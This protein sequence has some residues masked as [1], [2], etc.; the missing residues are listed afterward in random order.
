MN[1]KEAR[2]LARVNHIIMLKN[3]CSSL[4]DIFYSK[5]NEAVAY[6]KTSMVFK[7]ALYFDNVDEIKAFLEYIDLKGFR[8]DNSVYER[9]NEY[10]KNEHLVDANNI[11]VFTIRW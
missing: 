10:V 2:T 1:A 4:I 11:L 7:M 8:F 6:G 3:E 5:L 9:I